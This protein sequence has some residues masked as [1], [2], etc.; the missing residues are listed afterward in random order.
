MTKSRLS[1][2]AETARQRRWLVVIGS[3]GYA[4][5]AAVVVGFIAALVNYLN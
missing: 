2:E 3:I 4:S 1:L 5:M